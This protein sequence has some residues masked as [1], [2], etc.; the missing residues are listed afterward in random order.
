MKDVKAELEKYSLPEL[1]VLRNRVSDMQSRLWFAGGCVD[2]KRNEKYEIV[3]NTCD[4]IIKD[5][6]LKMFE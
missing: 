5:E 1:A 4:E 2:K 6:I 3:K